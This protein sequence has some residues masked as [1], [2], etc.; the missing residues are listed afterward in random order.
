MDRLT[1]VRNTT[2]SQTSSSVVHF[3]MGVTSMMAFHMSGSRMTASLD[4]VSTP[5]SDMALQVTPLGAVRMA[6]LRM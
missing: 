4:S 2:H 3:F 5:P 1:T 6:T